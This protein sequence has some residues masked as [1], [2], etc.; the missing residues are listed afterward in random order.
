[1]CWGKGGEEEV[2]QE[3][4]LSRFR[5]KSQ[6]NVNSD[7]VWQWEMVSSVGVAEWKG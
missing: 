3:H 1:M 6:S 5:G 7:S 2:D 4:T